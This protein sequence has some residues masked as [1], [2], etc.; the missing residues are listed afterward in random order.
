MFE[1]DICIS[2]TGN[3]GPTPMEDKPVGLI[4]I[5]IAYLDKIET[6]E[7]HLLGNRESIKKQ[8]VLIGIEKILN[9]LKKNK[10]ISS[11]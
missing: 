11:I 2:F 3:A 8:A 10:N 6:Y 1:S 4:Y 5:G 9:I 7:Y